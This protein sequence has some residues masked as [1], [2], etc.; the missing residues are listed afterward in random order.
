MITAIYMGLRGALGS[1]KNLVGKCAILGCD[2]R[3]Q[4]GSRF[5]ASHQPVVSRS[6]CKSSIAGGS[7]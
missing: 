5:C 7:Q 1:G 3:K 2:K 4:N 6:F